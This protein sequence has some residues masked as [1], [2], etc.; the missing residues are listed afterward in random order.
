VT[1]YTPLSVI[2]ATPD[3]EPTAVENGTELGVTAV[4]AFVATPPGG[5]TTLVVRLRGTVPGPR[6][7]LDLVA[8]PLVEPERA[9]IRI[10]RRDGGSLRAQGPAERDPG[11]TFELRGDGRI[12]ASAG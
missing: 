4:S 9:R 8:Q 12:T 11:R 10:H 1:L 2:D 6:Y 5:T 3:G 7:R